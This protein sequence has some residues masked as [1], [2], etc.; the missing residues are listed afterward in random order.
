M[1]QVRKTSDPWTVMVYSKF[2]VE[3]QK[4]FLIS[5]GNYVKIFE[6]GVE[7][8][9]RR[10]VWCMKDIYENICSSFRNLKILQWQINCKCFNPMEQI[11]ILFIAPFKSLKMIQVLENLLMEFNM[12]LILIFHLK[13]QILW[14]LKYYMIYLLVKFKYWSIRNHSRLAHNL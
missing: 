6:S 1:Y 9:L 13:F 5:H 12:M 14:M 8:Y 4:V 7:G 10:I 3:Y 2:W 11:W